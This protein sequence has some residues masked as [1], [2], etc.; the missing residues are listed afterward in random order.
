M[1]IRDSFLDPILR[2][3]TTTTVATTAA[4]AEAENGSAARETQDG[5]KEEPAAEAVEERV[6]ERSLPEALELAFDEEPD[7]ASVRPV[8]S[9]L[10]SQRHL[11]GYFDLT[12]AVFH[13]DKEHRWTAVGGKTVRL[14][15]PSQE[16]QQ[17]A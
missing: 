16:K 4:C 9:G 13:F 3:P 2:L 11:L 15:L 5:V 14:V 1:C 8:N 7:Q 10:T 6:E 17:L 12:V